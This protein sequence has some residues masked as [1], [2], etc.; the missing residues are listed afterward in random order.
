MTTRE[1]LV[2]A[3]ATG[4]LGGH[5]VRAAAEAGY[6]VRALVRDPARLSARVRSRCDEVFVGEATDPASLRGLFEGAALGFSSIGVRHFRRRPTIWE[7]DEAA[8][9][10]LVDEAERAGARRFAF[11]SL[12]QGDAR[13]GAL[14]VA[15]ARERVV[16]RLVASRMSAAVVRP[17]GFFNDLEEIFRMAASGRVWL[18]GD[19]AARF[20][21]IH[22]ADLAARVVEALAGSEDVAVSVGGPDVL[23]MR[24]AGQLAFDALGAPARFGHVPLWVVRSAASAAAPFNPNLS[25]FL[26]MF[27]MMADG[28]LVAPPYGRHHLADEMQRL[29]AGPARAP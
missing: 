21:P 22:G 9:L 7:V 2:V 5:V 11:V 15:E 6:R 1:T 3:G 20:N 28:D 26:R 13:R 14:P 19:G 4:Y 25:T 12:L 18:L 10:S 27:A 16:D 17:S 24:E 23:T 8:N 29:A